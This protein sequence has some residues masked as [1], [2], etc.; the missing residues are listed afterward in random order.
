ME[1]EEQIKKLLEMQADIE[2]ETVGVPEVI[3]IWGEQ[4]G[5]RAVW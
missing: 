1:K 2:K 4:G 3:E 5:E